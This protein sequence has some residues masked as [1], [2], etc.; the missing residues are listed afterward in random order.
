VLLCVRDGQ[1]APL[2]A[3]MGQEGVRE[4]AVGHT[5]ASVGIEALSAFRS[6]RRGVSPSNFLTG[7]SYK[8]GDFSDLLGGG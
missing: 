7:R 5:A 1:I 2:A 6:K 8:V 3:E 4:V